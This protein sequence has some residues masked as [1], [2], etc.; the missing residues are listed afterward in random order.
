MVTVGRCPLETVRGS[1]YTSPTCTL[2][3]YTSP[4][5]TPRLYTPPTFTPR[6][7]TPPTCVHIAYLWSTTVHTTPPTCVHIAYPYFTVHTAYLWS[8]ASGHF[9]PVR[10][11]SPLHGH[12]AVK[13]CPWNRTSIALVHG[14]PSS[15]PHPPP[16]HPTCHSLV[17][18]ERRIA[19]PPP[20][21]PPFNLTN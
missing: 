1:R 5:C 20:P 19:E 6:P 12:G 10:L 7:Y 9:Y 2:R 21:L 8:T 18:T 11:G 17:L 16:P 15:T 4:T 3:P 13:T 14:D